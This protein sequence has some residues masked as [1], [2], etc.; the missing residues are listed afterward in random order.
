M[1]AL[2]LVAILANGS[3]TSFPH[4]PGTGL[5][6]LNNNNYATSSLLYQQATTEYMNPPTYGRRL[7]QNLWP[8]LWGPTTTP[9]PKLWSPILSGV[10]I[11]DL[12]PNVSNETALKWLNVAV[13]FTKETE[14]IKHETKRIRDAM[15]KLYGN[16]KPKIHQILEDGLL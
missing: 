2:S 5:H 6:A 13:E 11:K 3:P 14:Q 7:S 1:F 8:Q 10:D 15:F 16:L 9:S 4:L 12:L